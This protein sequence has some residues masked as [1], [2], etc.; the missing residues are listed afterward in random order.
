MRG[1]GTSEVDGKVWR[2]RE[3]K[4]GS[5]AASTTGSVLPGASPASMSPSM[6]PRSARESDAA[7]LASDSGV[8]GGASELL[9]KRKRGVR[10]V[11]EGR[12]WKSLKQ[13]LNA[14]MY[15]LVPAHLPT[16]TNIEAPPARL[17]P[18]KYCDI[19]GAPTQYTDPKTKMFF[20]CTEAF[21]VIRQLPDNA[22]EEFLGIRNASNR[23]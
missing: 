16:Y 4:D 13:T 9:T 3:D 17:P 6:S 1:T 15:E 2:N 18:R 20:S 22:V 19:T 12:L 5:A 11:A 10:E 23:I 7:V 8:D 21:K 14:E